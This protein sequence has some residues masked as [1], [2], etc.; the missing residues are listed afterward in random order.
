MVLHVVRR[1]E[2]AVRGGCAGLVS[3]VGLTREGMGSGVV[4]I[5]AK[6]IVFSPDVD[7]HALLG[8]VEADGRAMD[9]MRAVDTA[10][11][12]FGP[13]AGPPGGEELLR[14]AGLRSGHVHLGRIEQVEIAV[15]A[16]ADESSIGQQGGRGGAE[17]FIDD[18][19]RRVLEHG[20]P[21]GK[22]QISRTL[23]ETNETFTQV[24]VAGGSGFR[25]AVAAAD[26]D[27]A[28]G[29]GDETFAGLPD[30]RLG[31]V[32][33]RAEDA[34]APESVGVVGEDPAMV[35]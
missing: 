2:R 4:A 29:V 6:K 7:Q 14:E 9:V 28:A 16:A 1:E 3:F 10:R 12:N 5:S 23:L 21:A 15:L 20:D 26:K 35:R 18:R 13:A 33:C 30:A 19:I 11:M 22:G 17:I 25:V 8:T 27:A 24:G 34:F 32:R 31:T